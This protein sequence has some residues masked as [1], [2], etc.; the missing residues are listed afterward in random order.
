MYTGNRDNQ[1]NLCQFWSTTGISI[2]QTI[3]QEILFTNFSFNKYFF[4]N[5]SKAGISQL[6]E[7]LASDL[8]N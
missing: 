3:W 1:Q 5:R 2:S 7:T 6:T 4:L 8:N